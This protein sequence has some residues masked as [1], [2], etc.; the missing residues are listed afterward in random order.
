MSIRAV[1]LVFAVIV[2]AVGGAMA[3]VAQAARLSPSNDAAPSEIASRP[4]IEFYLAHGDADACGAGCNE[5][6]A[7]EGKIDAG[8]ADRFRALLKKLKD[9]KPPVYFHSPGGK[10]KDALELGRLFR[11]RGFAVSVGH[12]IPRDCDND[13]KSDNS[14][15]AQK[16]S[17]TA[18]AAELSQ[19][20]AMCNSAC[21]FALAGG[22]VRLVPPTVRLGIHDIALDPDSKIPRGVPVATLL[23]SSHARIRS[24]LREMGIADALY[25]AVLATPNEKLTYLRR[26]D[27]V[28]FGLDRRDSGE[29]VWRFIDKPALKIRKLFFGP[30]DGDQPRYV[31]GVIEIGCSNNLLGGMYLMFARD[32]LASDPIVAATPAARLAMRGE[33]ISLRRAG[34]A[35]FYVR[36][37]RVTLDTLDRLGDGPAIELPGSEFN[38]MQRGNV[39]LTMDGFAAPYAKLRPICA[40]ALSARQATESQAQAKGAAD[41]PRAAALPQSQRSEK[42]G[43]LAEGR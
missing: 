43:A 15:E 11:E 2:C 24:Y 21:V 19:T 8:T 37:G 22:A 30:I 13:K 29:T 25:A 9:R 31:D 23:Q 7:A 27:L 5:W 20:G 17:G 10:I 36:T 4:A 3:A 39:A 12:T 28:S 1:F 35:N 41:G 40:T 6:I 18:I 14:C 33:L 34:A 32:L 38:R 26:D 42:A 16:R